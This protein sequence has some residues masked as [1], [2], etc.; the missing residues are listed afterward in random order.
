MVVAQVLGSDALVLLRGRGKVR[1]N[2]RGMG[3]VRASGG[4]RGKGRGRGRG[5]V[6]EVPSSCNLA[7]TSPYTL[8]PYPIPTPNLRLGDDLSLH[9]NPIP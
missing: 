8:T 3:R 1:A 7:T 5:R 4:V 2:V 9:P 6:K